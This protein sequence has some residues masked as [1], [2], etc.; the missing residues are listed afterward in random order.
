MNITGRFKRRYIPG[1]KVQARKDI[2]RYLR[3]AELSCKDRPS[4][5]VIRTRHFNFLVPGR[6]YTVRNSGHYRG[7]IVV[8]LEE[9][10]RE[11]ILYTSDMFEPGGDPS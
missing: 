1:T 11:E 7:Q 6:V 9:D 2:H 8:T 5:E 4:S 10:R 3:A